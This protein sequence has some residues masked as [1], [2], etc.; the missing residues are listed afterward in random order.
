MEQLA[1]HIHPI[2]VSST[3]NHA[4]NIVN[5]YTTF[6]QQDAGNNASSDFTGGSQSHT[7]SLSGSSK[8]A[9]SL[10]PYYALAYI[11]RTS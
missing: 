11:M 2:G 9:N 4:P 6:N 7:H 8:E 5:R 1:S 10:P 3:F